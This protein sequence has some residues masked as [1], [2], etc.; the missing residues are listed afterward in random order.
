M[1]DMGRKAMEQIRTAV[2]ELLEAKVPEEKAEQLAR[3][4]SEGHWTHDYP[5]TLEELRT[6]GLPVSDAIPVSILRL[7]D[8]YP[9]PLQRR[10]VTYRPERHGP[11]EAPRPQGGI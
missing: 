7:M 3:L 6:W 1:A 2:R 4:L 9:Q 11:G 10:N 8:L 5:L